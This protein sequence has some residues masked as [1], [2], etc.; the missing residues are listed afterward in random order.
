[1]LNCV[2]ANGVT[3]KDME[4]ALKYEVFDFPEILMFL[5]RFSRIRNAIQEE[6]EG[7]GTEEEVEEE[8]DYQTMNLKNLKKNLKKKLE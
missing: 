3:R 5:A 1:M 4:Y 2:D 8:S 7:E 6:I